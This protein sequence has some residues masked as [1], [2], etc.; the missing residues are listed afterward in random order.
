M[1]LAGD[2]FTRVH[3]F[4]VMEVFG[5]LRPMLSAP[6]PTFRRLVDQVLAEVGLVP[7]SPGSS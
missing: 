5:Q 6:G 3:G 4:V 1:S 2:V 7:T